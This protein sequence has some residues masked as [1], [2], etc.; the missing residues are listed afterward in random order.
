MIALSGRAVPLRREEQARET[1]SE[2]EEDISAISDEH[3]LCD[4]S[5]T[6]AAY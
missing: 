6:V 4:D 2:A 5:L 3:M 1:N